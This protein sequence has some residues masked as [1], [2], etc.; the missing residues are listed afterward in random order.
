MEDAFDSANFGL[1]RVLGALG[2][3]IWY[4]RVL[5]LTFA[6][7]LLGIG[8]SYILTAATDKAG[9]VDGMAVLS[10]IVFF[11]LQY[12]VSQEMIY[13]RTATILSHERVAS[14]AILVARVKNPA[15]AMLAKTA[16]IGR[17]YRGARL[18]E[19]ARAVNA[20]LRAVRNLDAIEQTSTEK[21]SD[22]GSVA[23]QDA[24][25]KSRLESEQKKAEAQLAS[26]DADLLTRV[27]DI[28]A[29]MDAS[30]VSGSTRWCTNAIMDIMIVTFAFPLSISM[31]TLMGR[32]FVVPQM[33]II[34]MLFGLYDVSLSAT[35]P[36]SP[37]F[38]PVLERMEKLLNAYDT[39]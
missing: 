31:F 26:D 39:N 28:V 16:V 25:K 20:I 9:I 4:A 24:E 14:A 6:V 23:T 13:A 7:T 3:V 36:F 22:K 35:N 29:L 18:D 1:L 12:S 32:A 21:Q 34:M 8:S 11:F 37:R 30:A 19:S 33:I 5:P 27:L 2:S 10:G 38:A 15:L 17:I